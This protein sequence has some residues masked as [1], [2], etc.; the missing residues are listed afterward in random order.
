MNSQCV[1]RIP[2]RLLYASYS[3]TLRGQRL[4]F[5]ALSKLSP[6]SYICAAVAPPI[7]VSKDD[8]WEVFLDSE[9]PYRDLKYALDSLGEAE[10]KFP[11][12]DQKKYKFLKSFE[13]A[14]SEG[15]VVLEFCPEFLAACISDQ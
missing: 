7:S 10:V 15:K 2:N 5:L 3:L 6:A 8:W 14:K 11:G 1:A 4:L 12:T 13:Y 9:Q